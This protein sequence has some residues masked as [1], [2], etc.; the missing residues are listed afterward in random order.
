MTDNTINTSV[1]SV[2]GPAPAPSELSMAKVWGL[3]WVEIPREF[4]GPKGRGAPS[5]CL[6]CSWRAGEMLSMTKW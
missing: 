5:L 3:E 4:W 2:K 6:I 1:I